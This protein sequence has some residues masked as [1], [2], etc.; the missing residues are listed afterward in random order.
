[1]A[2]LSANKPQQA[3]NGNVTGNIVWLK[4]SITTATLLLD[5]DAI[6]EQS[7]RPGV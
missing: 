5:V 2:S 6:G 7:H 1:M 4:I 3:A